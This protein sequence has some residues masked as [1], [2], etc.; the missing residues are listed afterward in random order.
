[1]KPVFLITAHLAASTARPCGK[2]R[3]VSVGGSGID[4]VA[5]HIYEFDG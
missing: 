5:V 2:S 4:H 1:M 3:E